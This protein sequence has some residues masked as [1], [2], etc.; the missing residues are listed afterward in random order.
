MIRAP[1]L[2]SNYPTVAALIILSVY[3]CCAS[4]SILKNQGR[5]IYSDH[6]NQRDLENLIHFR[7]RRSQIPRGQL[8]TFSSK[9]TGLGDLEASDALKKMNKRSGAMVKY[10]DENADPLDDFRPLMEKRRKSIVRNSRLNRRDLF[11]RGIDL[12]SLIE[13]GRREQQAVEAARDLI[14]LR[15]ILPRNVQPITSIESKEPQLYAIQK[16]LPPKRIPIILTRR[17][18]EQLDPTGEPNMDEDKRIEVNSNLQID[19]HEEQPAAGNHNYTPLVGEFG[20]KVSLLTT[21]KVQPDSVDNFDIISTY[22]GQ[23]FNEEDTSVGE[24]EPIS[25]QMLINPRPNLIVATTQTSLE[26]CSSD[27]E[28]KKT[29]GVDNKTDDAVS[30]NRSNQNYLPRIARALE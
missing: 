8:E 16:V 22:G 18:K 1:P 23:E 6:L 19:S 24:S 17:T 25:S 5:N 10:Y 14:K 11:G 12:N 28:L 15:Q 27:K 9:A 26:D 21:R 13:N 29:T 30:E 20:S 2:I 4:S 3:S 7:E